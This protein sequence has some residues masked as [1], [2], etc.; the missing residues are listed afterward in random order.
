MT[1][2]RIWFDRN[3]KNW[4][5]QLLDLQGNQIGDAEF[6]ATRQGVQQALRDRSMVAL[7]H[8][9]LGG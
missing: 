6:A 9:I 3:T 4:I 7:T 2:T 5:G 8:Q 1:T